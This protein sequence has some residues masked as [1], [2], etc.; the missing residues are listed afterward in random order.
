MS[1]GFETNRITIVLLSFNFF[2][3]PCAWVCPNNGALGPHGQHFSCSFSLCFL[4]LSFLNPLNYFLREHLH[5]SF[6]CMFCRD[7]DFQSSFVFSNENTFFT[8]VFFCCSTIVNF[9]HITFNFFFHFLILNLQ[10][11]QTY[12]FCTSQRIC[13]FWGVLVGIS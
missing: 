6:V 2:W 12:S 13:T 10:K 11:F 4:S 1:S 8:L 5:E 3:V 7:M 9:I